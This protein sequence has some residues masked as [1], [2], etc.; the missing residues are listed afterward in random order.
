[1]AGTHL[2]IYSP[3]M[4]RTAGQKRTASAFLYPPIEPF[5]QR[6]LDMGDGHRLYVEQ[7]GHPN[8]APVLVCHGGPGGGCSP[9]MRR[10]FDPA[11][12]RVVLFDQRG[13]GLSRPHASVTAN[14]TW[15]LVADIER[16]REALGIDSWTVF[17]G[18]WGATLALI[19]AETHPDRVRALVLRGVFLAMQSELDWFYG[20]GAGQFF[21]DLWQGFIAA[22]P[23]DE[24]HDLIAAYHKRLF[25]GDYAEEARYARAWAMW[26]NALATVDFDGLPGEAPP[27]YARAFAR[28]ENHYFTNAAFLEQD[29]QIL[30]DRHRI[31]HIPATI[32]QGRMDMICPPL[33][34]WRLAQGWRRASLR[35]VPAAGHALSEPGI[36]AALVAAMD[37][38]RD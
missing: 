9:A 38:L 8:G 28:L 33:S 36:S 13:C 2:P 14:T 20:G 17:G 23:E 5:D 30:R 37:R 35:I 24:R 34:S 7:S 1:M 29:G 25:S 3:I 26:E 15:H 27:D 11:H 31:E 12:Y 6:M 22:I 21:P 18:S 4:D 32:V 19:Y 16:I 10:F